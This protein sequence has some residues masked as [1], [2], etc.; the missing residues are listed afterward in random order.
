MHTAPMEVLLVPAEA[1]EPSGPEVVHK[2]ASGPEERERLLRESEVLRMASER[3]VAGLATVVSR[4]SGEAAEATLVTSAVAGPSL[5]VA[6]PLPVCEVAGVAV[7]VANL[8]AGLHEAGLVHGAVGPGHVVL[9]GAGGLI[10][11]GLGEGGEIGA[12]ATAG[13]GV[14]PPAR[15]DP[16]SDVAGWGMLVSH[17]LDW[18]AT[19]E[20]EP[21]VALRRTLGGRPARRRRPSP[22]P[23]RHADDD[24]RVLAA[25]AD[26]AQ[27]P[28]PAHRPTARSLAAAVTHRVP[29]ARMPG[30][31]AEPSTGAPRPTGLFAR[32][33][34]HL[35]AAPGEVAGGVPESLPEEQAPARR[36]QPVS[37]DRWAHQDRAVRDRRPFPWGRGA[38]P[39]GVPTPGREPDVKPPSGPG[40]DQGAGPPMRAG[41]GVDHLGRE[42]G[43]AAAGDAGV[44]EA[45]RAGSARNLRMPR[46]TTPARLGIALVAAIV[47]VVA[48]GLVAGGRHRG[49]APA[50]AAAAP[51][52]VGCRP[53]APP[54]ADVDGDGC[55][56]SVQWA[57]G[58]LLA[59]QAR[60]ALGAPG[61]AWAI[62]D[63][64]C[65][66]QR[67][68][69]I[70]QEGSLV[71]FDAWPGPGGELAGRPA[72]MVAGGRGLSVVPGPDGC[73]RPSIHRPGE[74]DVVVDAGPKP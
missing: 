14:A 1:D 64:D 52:Q 30:S 38:K 36:A 45:V 28:D 16:A 15:L 54:S 68:P 56:E 34:A 46:G 7:A 6:A 29:D 23:S 31:A 9:D 32:L 65:D 73:D 58:V 39:P 8:L 10:M 37:Q 59:G 25:L 71:V 11:V 12:P 55:E 63:W 5:A 49:R 35:A 43:S 42:E 57:D 33:P 18:S 41:L 69:A 3:G 47:L 51:P 48:G 74:A 24:R 67:T 40:S 19:G 20:E 26:Q 62:G 70:L 22:P 21:L 4:P 72:A 60:F 66:G 27:G 13:D 61:D 2:T 44:E 50:Q 53:A 17:L